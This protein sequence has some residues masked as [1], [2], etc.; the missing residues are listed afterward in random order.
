MAEMKFDCAHAI[1][2]SGQQTR[3]R[4]VSR[5]LLALVVL[6]CSTATGLSQEVPRWLPQ[7]DLHVHINVEQHLVSVRQRVQWTNHLNI[8]VQTIVFNNHSHYAIPDADI[9]VLAKTLEFLRLAPSDAMDF[10]GPPCHIDEVKVLSQGNTPALPVPFGYLPE[11]ATALEVKLPGVVEP[12]QTINLE[13]AFSLRLPQRQGRWGQWRG[14]TFLAQW[15]PLVAYHN[16]KTW[17]PTPF[18]PWH[19]PFCNPAGVFRAQITLPME[20]K[21]GCTGAIESIVD[22]QNGWKTVRVGE[23]VARDF[24]LSCSAL[25]QEAVGEIN[26]IKLRS[27]FLPNHTH[28]GK[29]MIKTAAETIPVYEKWFGRFPYRNFTVVESYFG[30][31]GNECGGLVMIDERVYGMPKMALGFVDHLLAHEICHQYFYNAVG[32]HGYAETWMDEGLA[33][34]FSHKLMDNKVGMNNA[35]LKYPR[36]LRWLPNIHRE[37]YR[38][39]GRVAAEGRGDIYPVVQEMPK[40]QH[41]PNLVANAYDRGGR[42]VGMIESRLG[43]AAMLDLM[44]IIYRKYYFRILRV[45]DFQKELEI[46]TGQSWDTFFQRWVYGNGMTDWSIQKVRVMHLKSEGEKSKACWTNRCLFTKGCDFLSQFRNDVDSTVGPYKVEVTLKQSKEYFEPTVLGFAFDNSDNYTLR[47]PVI[48]DNPVMVMEDLSACSQVLE[49]GRVRIEIILPRRPTQITVD[50][51]QILLDAEPANNSW[52]KKFR[53]R[54]TPLYFQLDETDL[55]NAYDRPNVLLGPWVFGQAFNNPWFTRAPLLGVKA[56]VYRTQQYNAGAFLAYRTNDQNIV[57]GVDGLIDHWPWDHT[58]VGFIA[59]HSLGALDSNNNTECS[60]AVLYGRYVMTYGSSLYLPPF[61]Y[62]ELFGDIQN[63]CLPDPRYP[64]PGADPFN[65]QSALGIHYHKYYLTPYWDPEG[66][67]ALDVTYRAGVPIIRGSDFQQVFGQV[68][69]IKYM[70]DP[71]DIFSSTPGLAWLT[72]TRWAFRLNGAA[73]LPDNGEFFTLGGGELYRGY[74][75]RERQGSMSWVASVEWRVPIIKDVRW[76]YFDRVAGIRN[77]YGAAFY[78]VGNA[79]LNGK[80]LGPV[81]H[82]VGGG[83]RMDVVWFGLIERT[84]LRFDFAKTVNDDTPVQFWFGLQ[85]PF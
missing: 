47:V 56:G 10:N 39:Y 8:P 53:Y 71:W 1:G 51:D 59:E 52:K 76:D 49:D 11:N 46:Y 45:A 65:D 13:M 66:G 5:G 26:G 28:Y 4:T 6:C 33:T 27:L 81:A 40:F 74:D 23:V 80:E 67:M 84:M 64:V 21:L 50:P 15:L 2:R 72:E 55:T 32:T 44:R 37:D 41:L 20:E 30:W 34:Y 18:I 62:V 38:Q 58:Q 14:V 16:G 54:F 7:Y 60:R 69:T 43:T 70:P 42:V 61:E 22:H 48:P 17:E 75:L 3:Y 57:A 73:A 77:I 78:D 36:G 82:A 31:N 12:G 68:S 35:M 19:Q 9:G 83:L 79:Y 25:Y 63:R 29:Q 85:H 24:S